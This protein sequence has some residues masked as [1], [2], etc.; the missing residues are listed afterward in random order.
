M[1]WYYSH[2]KLP[3]VTF[4]PTFGN[5][6]YADHFTP[7]LIIFTPIMAIFKNA[8]A[9]LVLQSL[10]FSFGGYAVYLF[11]KEKLQHTG[12]ALGITFLYFMYLGSQ[13]ALTFDVHESTLAAAAFPWLFYAVF[14]KKWLIVG[15][16]SLF[17]MGAKED[18]PPY[19]AIL[20]IYLFIT[21]MQRKLGVCMA[22]IGS[23]Y[24][25]L[26]IKVFMPHLAIHAI[27][28]FSNDLFP[29]SP[30][31]LFA[32][33]FDSSTKIQTMLD[34]FGEFLFLPLLS[35]WFLLFPLIHF[36]VNFIDPQ[37]P[38]RW[39]IYMHYRGLL[40]GIMSFGTIIGLSNVLTYGPSLFTKSY[41]KVIITF[42]L[43]CSALFFDITL[44]L[45]L[46]S[47]FKHSFYTKESWMTDIDKAIQ[48]IPKD[49]YIVTTNHIA[50][51]V[52]F[53]QHVYL[54][55]QHL[56]DAEYLLVDLTPN[57]PAIN[58]WTSAD[59]LPILQEEIQALISTKH[60]YKKVV[61]FHQVLLLKRIASF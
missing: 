21:N 3:L 19:I 11:G 23:I 53:N 43:V 27:K 7:S 30:Q 54:Y 9:L 61:Q 52:A 39:G 29:K 26:V 15:L 22:I 4:S 18:L 31:A 35:G 59:T 57:Q 50:P 33:F 60:T 37:F 8:I 48:Y 58:Y 45:P 2:F 55:P 6:S 34:S 36:L 16:L 44:H 49:A 56:A 13:F 47:I 42:L 1:F 12:L 14:K 51:H 24:F 32:I 38:G 46:N 41:T 5:I 17:I 40:S 10:L 20:G 28:T 25:F